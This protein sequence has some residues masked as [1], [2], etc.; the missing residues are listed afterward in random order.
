MLSINEL[1]NQSTNQVYWDP[2]PQHCLGC[3]DLA[4]GEA[5]KP[6]SFHHYVTLNTQMLSNKQLMNRSVNQVYL[7]SIP[8]H[9]LGC[10]DLAD[11]EAVK[12]GSFHHHIPLFT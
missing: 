6:G 1:A 12:P 11:G 3:V 7:D 8:L 9:C 2:I 5:V 4:D 10:V